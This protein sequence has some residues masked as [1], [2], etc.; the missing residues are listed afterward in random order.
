MIRFWSSGTSAAPI[1]TPRSPRAT[2][3]ASA[4]CRISSSASTPSPRSI[5][6]IT[7]AV[8]PEASIRVR[9]A[10]TSDAE[11][12]KESAT[13]SQPSSSANCRSSM[14]LRVSDGIGSDTPGRFT[15][16]CDC[17]VPP[18]STSQLARPRSTRSTRSR[19]EPSSI[20]TSLPACSTEPS[21]AGATGRS[22]P[23][24]TSSPAIVIRSPRTRS[25]DSPVQVADAQL[26]ALEVGD[27]R[28]RAVLRLAL[29]GDQAC[30]LRVVL[31]RAVREVQ[32][33][34][35]DHPDELTQRVGGRRRRTD[36]GDDL[37][38][39][40]NDGHAYRLESWGPMV[41]HEPLLRRSDRERRRACAR[42]EP[43]SA[44]TRGRRTDSLIETRAGRPSG[45]GTSRGR[46]AAP[47]SAGV[48]CTSRR[49]RSGP[50]RR[51]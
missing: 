37:R 28:D 17:T 21:T 48:G 4:N 23:L 9:S 29:F 19:T 45:P 46:R 22:S 8:E 12:T 24:A 15:P 43:G 11:R 51:S 10:C 47:R 18:T 26:R 39:T 49:D 44:A 7:C 5:F 33:G 36:R 30:G 31:V 25:T 42:A 13:K 20:S 32:A 50:E 40:W 3:T 38:A 34:A 41:P 6:A 35:V 27:D 16:L 2:I 1:S 14:S